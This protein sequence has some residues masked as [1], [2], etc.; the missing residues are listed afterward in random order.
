M[1]Q[2]SALGFSCALLALLFS[3]KVRAATSVDNSIQAHNFSTSISVSPRLVFGRPNLESRPVQSGSRPDVAQTTKSRRRAR[4]SEPSHH[5]VAVEAGAQQD[6]RGLQTKQTYGGPGQ[7][8]RMTA[9]GEAN[10]IGD[11]SAMGE[12]ESGRVRLH[13]MLGHPPRHGH[14]HQQGQV[15]RSSTLR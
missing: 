7:T 1:H 10:K 4:S 5:K 13:S 11:R 9:P 12:L 2:G 6:L 3:I 15:G 8:P 14:P